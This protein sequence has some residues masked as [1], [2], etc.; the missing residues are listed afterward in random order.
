MYYVISESPLKTKNHM[1]MDI[2]HKKIKLF[3]WLLINYCK[4]FV[5]IEMFQIQ[6][7][8][9]KK[10]SIANSNIFFM[11]EIHFQL[12]QNL[13]FYSQMEKSLWKFTKTFLLCKFHG[14]RIFKVPSTFR[15][16]IFLSFFKFYRL[17]FQRIFWIR[18]M[19][20][21]V[22]FGENT[23]HLHWSFWRNWL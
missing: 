1:K 10:V 15:Y 9:I 13:N 6:I 3:H 18:L 20:D 4:K 14:S 19:V 8:K 11:I 12:F 2:S 7:F 16:V 21:S 17:N 23:R 22:R 5:Q